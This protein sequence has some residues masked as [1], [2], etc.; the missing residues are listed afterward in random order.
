MT[1]N[2]AIEQLKQ[3]GWC[4]KPMIEFHSDRDVALVAVEK[5]G[6]NLSHLSG[7]LKDDKEVLQTTN[8]KPV[9]A[10]FVPSTKKGIA[11]SENVVPKESSNILYAQVINNGF[12]LVNSE[13]KVVY[14]IKQSG[15]SNVYLVEGQQAIIY[16]LDSK[17]ILEFYEND[18]LK[19]EILNIKF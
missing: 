5:N 13:P 10:V 1:K 8:V 19:K 6:Y 7:E 11:D 17:W 9:V 12:Q 2:E 18:T 4:F 14:K 16:Q 15:L 3:D